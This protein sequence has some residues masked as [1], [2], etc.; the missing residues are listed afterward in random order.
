MQNFAAAKKYLDSQHSNNSTLFFNIQEADDETSMYCITCGHEI[1]S[2]TA[3][4]HL[5]KCFIKYE[6][7]A[8][9]GSRHRTRID[10]QS[11]FCDFYNTA[12]G[13]YCKRLRVSLL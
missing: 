7:Q 5:E 3:V 2:R 4:K 8:S 13:T 12:N 9:F 1:H 6:A 11:M 10:G